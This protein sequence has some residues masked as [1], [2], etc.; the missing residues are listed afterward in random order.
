M[1]D[2]ANNMRELLQAAD[3]RLDGAEIGAAAGLVDTL[4]RW[5]PLEEMGLSVG[6]MFEALEW[7][8]THADPS[9]ED[10]NETIVSPVAS[11]KVREGTWRYVP[12]RA[13]LDREGDKKKIALYQAF[14]RDGGAGASGA[15]IEVGSMED[16]SERND[17]TTAKGQAAADSEVGAPVKGQVDSKTAEQDS[18]TGLWT[19]KLSRKKPKD[20][21]ISSVEVSPAGKTTSTTHTEAAAQLGA[22]SLT[23]GHVLT[24]KNK[25]TDAGNNETTAV[26]EQP[27]DQTATSKH[28]T[29][30]EIDTTDTHTEGVAIT[31]FTPVAGHARSVEQFPTKAGNVK[32]A[33][34]D[35]QPVA[36]DTGWIDFVTYGGT[37]YVRSF[38]NIT[39]VAVNAIIAACTNGMHNN[40][41][42]RQDSTFGRYSGT[43]TRSPRAP[44]GS[45]GPDPVD[46][47]TYSGKTV[48]GPYIFRRIEIVDPAS[49]ESTWQDEKRRATYALSGGFTSKGTT[50]WASIDGGV[51]VCAEWGSSV[52]RVGTSLYQWKKC[53]LTYEGSWE[54]E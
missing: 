3:W 26:N 1:S 31:D 43:I 2:I 44:S 49:G 4:T 48:Y 42:V 19:N 6:Q 30:S 36:Q 10:A 18:K 15:G 37:G 45:S 46:Q 27:S 7:L 32:T 22:P 50:A 5:V 29:A 54:E 25:P 35:K 53:A 20:Q 33:D 40:V 51:F 21:V 39:Q 24:N 16:F 52:T 12:R 28:V 11:G 41:S 17:S 23:V 14:V 9:I 47:Y 8:K 13:Y 38:E 34:T